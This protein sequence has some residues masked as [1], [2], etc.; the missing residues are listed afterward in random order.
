VLVA[1]PGRDSVFQ[2][3]N[4]NV[5]Q[6]RAVAANSCAAFIDGNELFRKSMTAEQIGSYWPRYEAHWYKRG[7]DRMAEFLVPELTR[8]R[9][10]GVISTK[11]CQ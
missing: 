7:G 6:L 5:E 3:P 9:E 10:S 2:T 4:S 1:L 8:V 11:A